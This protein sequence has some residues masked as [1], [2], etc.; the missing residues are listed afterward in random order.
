MQRQVLAH[1]SL[2]HHPLQE[3][4]FHL[5]ISFAHIKLKRHEAFFAVVTV[6]KRV[7]EFKSGINIIG[8]EPPWEESTLGNGDY[9]GQY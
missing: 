6:P 9:I 3:A 2:P 7:E 5:I 1:A 4:P 8:D